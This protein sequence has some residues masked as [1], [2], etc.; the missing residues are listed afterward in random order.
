MRGPDLRG[1]RVAITG[2]TSGIGLGIARVLAGQ[3]ARVAVCGLEDAEATAASL[4]GEAFGRDADLAEPDAPGAFVAA[5]CEALGGL[6]AVVANAGMP[7]GG[8]LE[9]GEKAWRRSVS[10]N[11]TAAMATCEHGA[12]A[13]EGAGD[14]VIVGSL[15]ARRPGANSAYVAANGGLAV[16]AE[17]FRREA[18]PRGLHVTLIEPGRTA[19][20]LHAGLTPEEMARE[21]RAGRMLEPEDVGRAVAFALT[22]PDGFVLS[23]LRCEPLLDA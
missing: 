3:G 16:F 1:R 21:V 22:T 7:A 10:V 6:D 14:V 8:L 12:R 23:G 9:M 5:A 18:A 19:S 20:A 15:A 2:G 4:P 13:I 11:L 17:G